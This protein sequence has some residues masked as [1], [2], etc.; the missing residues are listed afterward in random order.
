MSLTTKDIKAYSLLASA[1]VLVL[2]LA[3]GIR[4]SATQTRGPI[5]NN[6]DAPTSITIA[7]Q[8]SF[9]VGGTEVTAPGKF[10][11]TVRITSDEGQSFQIDHLYAQ[12]QIP[13]NPRRFPLVMIHGAG[14]MGKTWESTPDGRV[15]WATNLTPLR[16]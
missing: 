3:T 4:Y 7:K 6:Q 9:F 11:P 16:G 8:G 1:S 12:Y 14:Q 13:Q 15:L 10:D 2:F 5:L